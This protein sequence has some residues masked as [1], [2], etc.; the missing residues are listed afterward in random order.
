L[1][2]LFEI[3]LTFE[4]SHKTLGS[5]FGA[6]MQIFI[7]LSVQLYAV[8]PCCAMCSFA[9]GFH[10]VS[11]LYTRLP[12][13]STPSYPASMPFHTVVSYEHR[14]LPSFLVRL[15]L[16]SHSTR[17]CSLSESRWLLG[18]PFVLQCGHAGHLRA[19]GLP[20][21]LVVRWRR[22][23][24]QVAQV[25]VGHWFESG[26]SLASPGFRLRFVLPVFSLVLLGA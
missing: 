17:P 6:V 23:C 2:F 21:L 4:R 26:W 13:R 15:L 8:C 9:T 14:T 1:F 3:V 5:N 11:P 10:A 7:V 25:S 18:S 20:C 24:L 12:C 22:D 16:F 19:S